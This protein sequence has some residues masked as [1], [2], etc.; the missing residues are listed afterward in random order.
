MVPSSF[1]SR[2]W[3]YDVQRF[4]Q[5]GLLPKKKGDLNAGQ[6]ETNKSPHSKDAWWGWWDKAEREAAFFIKTKPRVGA[7]RPFSPGKTQSP[8]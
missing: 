1:S 4:T 5:W 6:P 7:A 8:L 2:Q 3:G